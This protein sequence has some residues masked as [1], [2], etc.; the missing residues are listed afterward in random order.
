MTYACHDN[1]DKLGCMVRIVVDSILPHAECGPNDHRK[2]APRDQII[3]LLYFFIELRNEQLILNRSG[4]SR[5][6]NELSRMTEIKNDVII[7]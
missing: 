2:N 7:M 1:H 6:I 4:T 3:Q 5:S